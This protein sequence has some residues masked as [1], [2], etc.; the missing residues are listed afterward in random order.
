MENGCIFRGEQLARQVIRK[1]FLRD[2]SEKMGTFYKAK[3]FLGQ[4]SNPT[5]VY[6]LE[7]SCVRKLWNIFY[8]TL[9][10]IREVKREIYIFFLI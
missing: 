5:N 7:C 8:A 10:K 4:E 6:K 3:D 9:S 1:S 2:R